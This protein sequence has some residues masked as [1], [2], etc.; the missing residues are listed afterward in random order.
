MNAVPVP[1][2]DDAVLASWVEFAIERLGQRTYANMFF[3]SLETTAD[4]SAPI[5]RAG[6]ARW[7]TEESFNCLACNGYDIKRD[8]GYGR[9][10]LANL[11]ATLNLFAFALNAVMDCVSDLWRQCRERAGIRRTFFEELRFLTQ[12]FCFPCWTVLFET[13]PKN[14]PLPGP[15]MPA[16]STPA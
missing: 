12:W 15:P 8:L 6:R 1:D 11:L 9:Y 14:R 13:M 7:K 4:N 2:S 3:T 16:V 5:A 10:G